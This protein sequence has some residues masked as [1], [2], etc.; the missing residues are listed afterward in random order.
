MA[1]PLAGQGL[2]PEITMLTR[3]FL[4]AAGLFGFAAEATALLMLVLPVYWS[5]SGLMARSRRLPCAQA[6]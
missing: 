4:D 5:L 2:I 1:Q 3:L 6:A